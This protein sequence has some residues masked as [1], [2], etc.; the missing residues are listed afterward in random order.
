MP[1][2]AFE[3][4][5]MSGRRVHGIE[6][7]TDEIALDRV[8]SARDLVMVD[9]RAGRGA[10]RAKKASTRTLID[11]CYHMAT[12]Y[13]AGIPLLEGLRD[14][15]ESGESPIAEELADVARKVESV[16]QLSQAMAD[17]PRIFPELVRSLIMAGEETGRLD[18]IL[19]D[20][21]RYLEWREELR[22]KVIGALSYPAIVLVGLV[23]LCVL[24]TTVV[25]PT[26]LD[27]FV[28][29]GVDLPLATRA[30]L[31]IHHF[32][33]AW[34][35]H[36]LAGIVATT[37]TAAAV[38]RTER[39]RFRFHQLQLKAPLFGPLLTMVEMS[40]LA[41]NLGILYTAGIPIV[42]CMELVKEIVGNRA[43]RAV[44][45]DARLLVTRGRGL[46]ESLAQGGL[47]PRMV[48]RMV[49]LGE[50]SGN[51]SGSLEHV[52]RYYDREVPPRIDAILTVFN[53]LVVVVLGAV[54]CVVAFAIF[55]PLYQMMGNINAG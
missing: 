24:L 11:F 14:L 34:G 55:V 26:F 48:I 53:T 37:L 50:T 25:L 35:L 32:L 40:R 54:L 29:L 21:V 19:R 2:Y 49:A 30:L 17:Y 1:R 15:Q 38:V 46:A 51:L 52:S 6:H 12:V 10:L 31:A 7:A 8:L 43:V 44:V 33:A 28:E 18:T 16:S 41:H 20:L 42:R 39:G 3:A 22:R 45:E 4:R 9:A 27:L 36:L 23:G 5:D 47:M 13:E